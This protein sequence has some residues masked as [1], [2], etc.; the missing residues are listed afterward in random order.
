MKTEVTDTIKKYESA[1]KDAVN[2]DRE[3]DKAKKMA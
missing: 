3:L 2:R 1:N